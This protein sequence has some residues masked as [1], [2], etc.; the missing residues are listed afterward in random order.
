MTGTAEKKGGTSAIEQA[1][2]DALESVERIEQ[3]SVR[4]ESS[5]NAGLDEIDV[6]VEAEEQEMD[7]VDVSAEAQAGADVEAGAGD[8]VGEATDLTEEQ[9]LKEKLL[10]MAADFENFRKRTRRE[11]DDLRRFGVE[12]M[13][14]ELLPVI[15]NMQRALQHAD[16][17]DDPIIQGIQMVSKQFVDVLSSY[18]VKA[19]DSVDQVFDPMVHEALSQVADSGKEPGSIVEV[20]HPGYMIHERLLRPAKVVVAAAPAADS[21]DNT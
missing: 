4:H 6:E 7:V 12:R 13:A 3:E 8:D 21:E 16:G 11:Q 15:D 2:Q 5:S 1:M 17:A 19:F 10:R 20:L 9:Q 14:S 18:G